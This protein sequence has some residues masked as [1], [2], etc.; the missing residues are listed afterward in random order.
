MVPNRTEKAIRPGAFEKWDEIEN[1][2]LLTWDRLA[3]EPRPLQ[4]R[5]QF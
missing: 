3:S 2:H 5:M 4:A 1:T